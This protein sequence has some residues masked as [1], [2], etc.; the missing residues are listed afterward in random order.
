MCVN[1]YHLRGN[2][3]GKFLGDPEMLFKGL[4]AKHLLQHIYGL[5][6]PPF[7]KQSSCDP[8]VAAGGAHLHIPGSWSVLKVN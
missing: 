2:V 1:W 5:G 3:S 4:G 7:T 8:L 6:S